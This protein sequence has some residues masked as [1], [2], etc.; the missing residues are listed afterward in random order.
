MNTKIEIFKIHPFECKGLEEYLE[1]QALKG[2]KLKNIYDRYLVFK[3]IEPKEL[4]YSV[5][6]LDEISFLDAAN[7]DPALNFREYCTE[8]GWDFI[9]EWQKLQIFSYEGEQN[10]IPINTDEA[11]K[12]EKIKKSS[13][14][15]VIL[16]F[17]LAIML[18][19]NIG[20]NF[21]IFLNPHAFSSNLLVL[22]SPFVLGLDIIAIIDVCSYIKFLVKG[23]KK[24]NINEKV[25]YSTYK[26]LK[27]KLRFYKGYFISY[28][29]ML[30][31]AGIQ[32]GLLILA[33]IPIVVIGSIV[34]YGI[35][36]WIGTKD[37]K[38]EKK[39]N[40]IILSNFI[41]IPIFTLLLV[42]T[43]LLSGVIGMETEKQSNNTSSISDEDFGLYDIKEEIYIDKSEGI[44]ASY[45]FCQ[46]NYIGYQEFKGNYEWVNKYYFNELMKRYEKWDGDYTK[47]NALKENY[48]YEVYKNESGRGY[49]FYTSHK[50]IEFTL[51]DTDISEENIIKTV[52][53]KMIK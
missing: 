6:I 16:D 33:I 23:K 20:M 31:V 48:D 51:Y 38:R 5:E 17:L 53:E 37:Y 26:S 27:M 14:K 3:R 13:L 30:L 42:A 18:S 32:S 36:K 52:Y 45:T 15:S 8:A 34:M 29:I 43:M 10:I 11:C 4:K 25:E 49:I 2:W 19:F 21:F 12:F 22:L 24:L 50:T 35:W 39:Q 47:I 9:C 1:D 46:D 41:V 44:L 40:L 28:I 7:S